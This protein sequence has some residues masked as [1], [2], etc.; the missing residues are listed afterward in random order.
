[1]VYGSSDK[2]GAYPANDPVEPRQILLTVLTLL[3]IPT[4]IPDQ[5]GRVVPLFEGFH[6]VERLYG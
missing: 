3:G 6:P 2:H 1:L 5:Q 4:A